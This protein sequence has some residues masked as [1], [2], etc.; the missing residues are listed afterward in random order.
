[1]RHGNAMAGD[2]E[3]PYEQLAQQA[4]AR[5]ERAA[6]RAAQAQRRADE[7]R[8]Y[9]KALREGRDPAPPVDELSIARA[10]ALAEESAR[11]SA[12]AHLEAATSHELAAKM[13]E[14]AARQIPGQAQ[15]H[16]REA[17]R[18]RDQAAAD[19]RLSLE[20]AD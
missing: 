18:H 20:D 5:G 9:F 2:R 17:Q 19:E 12:R 16:R 4:R 15:Q 14:R 1:M 11:R 8:S 3:D 6:R 7:L 13:H 10:R